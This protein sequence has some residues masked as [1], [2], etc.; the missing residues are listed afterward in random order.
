MRSKFVTVRVQRALSTEI[1]TDLP[2]YS[3]LFSLANEIEFQDGFDI[4]MA[5]KTISQT[6]TFA[7]NYCLDGKTALIIICSLYD[8]HCHD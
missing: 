6:P 8:R 3:F 1:S 4:S 2:F 7:P 5:L